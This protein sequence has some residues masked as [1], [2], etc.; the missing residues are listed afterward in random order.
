MFLPVLPGYDDKCHS[1]SYRLVE[2]HGTLQQEAHQLVGQAKRRVTKIRSIA[3]GGGIFDPFSNFDNS[4]P[5]VAGVV[6]SGVV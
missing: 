2:Q 5:E 1:R 6:I 3:V 4:R